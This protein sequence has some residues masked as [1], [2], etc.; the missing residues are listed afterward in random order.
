M[1]SKVIKGFSW[2]EE[3]YKINPYPEKEDEDD[4]ETDDEL[5]IRY[6]IAMRTPA[7]SG[8]AHHY[9]NWASEVEGVG[10]IKILPLWNGNGTVKVLFLDSNGQTASDELI[11]KVYNHIEENRPIGATV[12]V[13]SASVK[14]VRIEVSVSGTLD[15]E[16]LISDIMTYALTKGLD[17]RY[18]S[19]AKVGDLIMNQDSVDDYEYDSLLLNGSRQVNFN[20]EEILGISEVIVSAYDPH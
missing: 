19:A 7:T 6:A 2:Q 5:F 1:Y 4:E 17:L 15:V 8:N 3:R 16:Q 20:S 13:V 18:L 11:Q 12:T 10:V 9:Y 14:N